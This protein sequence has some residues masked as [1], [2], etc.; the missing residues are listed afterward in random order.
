MCIRDR[1]LL[2]FLG[3][4]DNRVGGA[5]LNPANFAMVGVGGMLRSPLDLLL[6]ALTVATTAA[7]LFAHATRDARRPQRTASSLPWNLIGGVLAALLVAAAV[8]GAF[9]FV[10]RVVADSN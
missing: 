1:L 7:L 8:R 2:A 6:T 10:G 3:L 4:P 9:G 5:L